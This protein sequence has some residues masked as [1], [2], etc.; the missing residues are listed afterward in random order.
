MKDRIEQELR[1][2]IGQPLSEVF[3]VADMECFAFGHLVPVK[4]FK[5]EETESY[6][7]ALHIQCAW[8]ITGPAGIVVASRDRYY[9]P[10]EPDTEPPDWEW[11]KFNRCDERMASFLE[12]DRESHL[13]VQFIQAGEV[14]SVRI[15]LGQGFTLE[16]FPDDSLGGEYW[17]FFQRPSQGDHFVVTSQGIE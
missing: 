3:R 7:Y 11:D 13:V 2:L 15:G 6:E 8:R 10:G 4:N 12:E 14:G 9:P 17:R 1:I 16:V 5:G